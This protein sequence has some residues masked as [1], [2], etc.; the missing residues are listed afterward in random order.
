VAVR[1][2][3]EDGLDSDAVEQLADDLDEQLREAVPEVAEV[4]IDPTSPSDA[5]RRARSHLEPA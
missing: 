5:Q 4:F 3:L 2:D 1:L